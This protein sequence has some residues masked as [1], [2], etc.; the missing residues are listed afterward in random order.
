MAE[1]AW[2]QTD[3]KPGPQRPPGVVCGSAL[4]RRSWEV[5]VSAFFLSIGWGA[6]VLLVP[7]KTA[8]LLAVVLLDV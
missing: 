3:W 1:I 7:L 2:T 4:P 8:C 5:V 6:E